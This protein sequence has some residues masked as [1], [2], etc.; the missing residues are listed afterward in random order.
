[1]SLTLHPFKLNLNLL[2][3]ILHCFNDINIFVRYHINIVLQSF[4]KYFLINLKDNS[5]PEMSFDQ[6]KI[7]LYFIANYIKVKGIIPDEEMMLVLTNFFWKSNKKRKRKKN[8]KQKYK[9]R[10]YYTRK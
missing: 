9:T 10:K 4:Y 6:M 7:Y 3:E 2:G 1:M 5:Y 8:N